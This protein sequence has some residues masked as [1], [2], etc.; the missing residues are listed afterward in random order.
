MINLI[1]LTCLYEAQ[2]QTWQDTWQEKNL[3]QKQL[4]L[5]GKSS[6]VRKSQQP[7]HA[8]LEAQVSSPS[9]YNYALVSAL[10]CTSHVDH[11][12]LSRDEAQP[13]R[14]DGLALYPQS[15]GY[16]SYLCASSILFF[17]SSRAFSIRI[18]KITSISGVFRN[19]Q[20]NMLEFK[21]PK[22]KYELCDSKPIL[23]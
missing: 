14:W 15:E 7:C 22:K 8:P 18:V 2:Y 17:S 16:C 9:S 11:C 12:H 1:S 6:H 4:G 23:I 20:K 10:T 19:P 13:R 3:S 5:I 21:F